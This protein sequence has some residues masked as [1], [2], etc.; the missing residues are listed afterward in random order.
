MLLVPEGEDANNSQVEDPDKMTGSD[1]FLP[2]L[3]KVFSLSLKYNYNL[4]M[5]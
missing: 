2:F 4:S 3:K 5:V 1:I